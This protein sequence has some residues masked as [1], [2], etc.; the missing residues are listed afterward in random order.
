MEERTLDIAGDRWP[1]LIVRE[2]A[3]GQR[4]VH[5]PAGRGDGARRRRRL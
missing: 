2:F 5:R 3:P 4:W 1:L